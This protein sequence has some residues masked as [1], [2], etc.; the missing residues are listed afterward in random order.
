VYLNG[1]KTGELVVKEV[2]T[3]RQVLHPVLVFG[4]PFLLSRSRAAVS[5]T[6]EVEV[7]DIL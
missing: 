7:A 5:D 3:Y 6:G 1:I 4:N 2:E